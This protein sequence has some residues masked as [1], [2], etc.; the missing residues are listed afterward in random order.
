MAFARWFLRAGGRSL[1]QLLALRLLLQREGALPWRL[2]DFLE[3]MTRLGLLRRAGSGHLF[4]HRL[5]M[6]HFAEP[7]E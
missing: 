2:V 5:L 6:E 4:P 1:L 3:E 7:S